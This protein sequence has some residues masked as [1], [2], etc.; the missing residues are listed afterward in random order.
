MTRP[1]NIEAMLERQA[2][3]WDVRER[4][5]AEGGESARRALA[6][7]AEGPWITISRQAGALGQEVAHRL[8]DELHWQAFD[9]EILSAIAENSNTRAAVLSRLDETATGTVNDYLSQMVVRGDPGQAAYLEHLVRVVWGLARQG[10][11]IILGRGANYFLDPRFG[12]RVRLIAPFDTR[13]ERLAQREGLAPRDAAERV[14]RNDVR[15][16]AFIRQVY[17]RE[18]DDPSGFDLVLN[19]GALDVETA[20]SAILA[21]LRHKLQ[22]PG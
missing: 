15:Q 17:G 5:A 21:A 1:L 3:Y 14:R 16:A 6:H 11:A 9:K 12:L 10:N 8:A 7:L 4:I 20:A 19:M 18:V 22:A 2:R 13:V